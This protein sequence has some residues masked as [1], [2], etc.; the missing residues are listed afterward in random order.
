MNTTM[1]QEADKATSP[2]L[3]LADEQP[4][5]AA[6]ENENAAQGETAT[7]GNDG[8]EGALPGVSASSTETR[9]SHEDDME[10]L[11]RIR[12]RLSEAESRELAAAEN[13]KAAKKSKDAIQE[14]LNEFIDEMRQPN[15]FKQGD[16]ESS[17]STSSDQDESTASPKAWR[18]TTLSELGISEKTA[19][20]MID[21]HP[22]LKT[23]GDIA[24]FTAS[25]ALLTDV[26]GVGEASA[27]KIEDACNRFWE[28]YAGPRPQ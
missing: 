9:P 27:Q 12:D 23:L 6:N 7:A 10:Q 13:H 8:A 14:E 16:G 26:K 20:K 2:N 19:E 3:K 28:T 22:S 15:L 4:N 24:D 21:H 17:K 18:A 5:E 11:F 25:G 1:E